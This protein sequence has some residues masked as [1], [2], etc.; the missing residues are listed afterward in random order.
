MEATI[1]PF[2]LKVVNQL[3]CGTVLPTAPAVYSYR[4]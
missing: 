1:A 3:V 2:L 4:K